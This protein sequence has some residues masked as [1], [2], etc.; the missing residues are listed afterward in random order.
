ML[1]LVSQCTFH[2]I[3]MYVY[4]MLCMYTCRGELSEEML[5]LWYSSR[6]EQIDSLSGQVG[7]V[8]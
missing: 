8:L 4:S 7:M 6:A 3:L 1:L 2:G 5:T